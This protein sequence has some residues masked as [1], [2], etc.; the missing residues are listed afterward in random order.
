MFYYDFHGNFNIFIK[1]A[2]SVI[3]HQIFTKRCDCTN[4]CYLLSHENCNLKTQQVRSEWLLFNT[5]SAI[6]PAISWRE[7]FDAVGNTHCV[8]R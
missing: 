1:R 8:Y 4:H 6:F 5:N 7:Q 2:H 3:V